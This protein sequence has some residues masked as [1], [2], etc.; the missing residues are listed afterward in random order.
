MRIGDSYH[1][2]DITGSFDAIVKGKSMQRSFRRHSLRIIS[3][4]MPTARF[5]VWRRRPRF[6]KTER[7]DHER[8]FPDST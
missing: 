8:P 5:T 1:Q 3:P 7:F 2:Q 4:G 6:S